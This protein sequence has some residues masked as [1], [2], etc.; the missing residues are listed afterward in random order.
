MK[1]KAKKKHKK[2]NA[3][4]PESEASMTKAEFERIIRRLG[5]TIEPAERAVLEA[6]AEEKRELVEHDRMSHKIYH[7]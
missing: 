1:K 2:Q 4:S 6:T 7:D 3:A 5:G